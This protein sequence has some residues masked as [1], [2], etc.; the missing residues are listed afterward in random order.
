MI[1]FEVLGDVDVLRLQIALAREG[2]EL[3]HERRRL[4]GSDERGEELAPE[5]R[6]LLHVLRHRIDIGADHHQ[7]VVEVV[8]DAAGEAADR[9]HLLGVPKLALGLLAHRRLLVQ[10][11][12]RLDDVTLEFGLEMALQFLRLLQRLHVDRRGEPMGLPPLAVQDHDRRGGDDVRAIGAVMPAQPHLHRVVP[13][14]PHGDLAQAQHPAAIVRVRHRGSLVSVGQKSDAGV[15]ARAAVLEDRASG[16]SEHPHERGQAFRQGE[17]AV[18]AFPRSLRPPLERLGEGA[19][20]TGE[21][22]DLHDA[23]ARRIRLLASRHARRRSGHSAQGR[24]DHPRAPRNQSDRCRGEQG[25]A[26]ED[27]PA[28]GRRHNGADERQRRQRDGAA[29]ECELNGQREAAHG[30]FYKDR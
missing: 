27:R 5:L 21:A 2:E 8:G 30:P 9:L 1:E 14:L 6:L 11:P 12:G 13:P 17:I 10:L 15:L 19:D 3:R 24:G 16:L 22:V 25:R 28:R 7:L 23:G 29:R 4:I 18:L 20:R 26:G